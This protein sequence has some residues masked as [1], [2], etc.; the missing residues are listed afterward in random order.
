MQK[1]IAFKQPGLMQVCSLSALTIAPV[2]N[3][4]KINVGIIVIFAI[5]KR[6]LK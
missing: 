6:E 1:L 3:P 2:M 4:A 5:L